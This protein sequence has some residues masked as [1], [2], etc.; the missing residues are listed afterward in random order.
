VATQLR[1]PVTTDRKIFR[2]YLPTDLHHQL[3]ALA[4]A[5]Q[6]SLSG[7]IVWLLQ[8]ALEQAENTTS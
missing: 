4:D 8:R 1:G 6:R 7:Q 3:E 5:E 2:L